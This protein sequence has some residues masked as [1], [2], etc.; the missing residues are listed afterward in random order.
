MVYHEISRAR[1]AKGAV[2]LF[3]P[4][5]RKALIN[6]IHN[7]Y[8]LIEYYVRVIGYTLGHSVLPLE[9]I[10]SS[11]VY[12]YVKYVFTDMH[13]LSLLWGARAPPFL[14]LFNCALSCRIKRVENIYVLCSV[15]KVERITVCIAPAVRRGEANLC[16]SR[17]VVYN[18][19]R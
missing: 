8:I 9:Q 2:K 12:S 19:E 11:V 16:K 4:L 7:G 6:R 1:T 3:K 5:C 10:R 17:T 14:V 15:R 18:V 13:F